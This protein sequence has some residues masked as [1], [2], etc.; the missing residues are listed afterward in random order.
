MSNLRTLLFSEQSGA[1]EDLGR[2]AASARAAPTQVRPGSLRS[3]MHRRQPVS[4]R[5]LPAQAVSGV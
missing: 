4:G 2:G 3:H 5:G 1:E